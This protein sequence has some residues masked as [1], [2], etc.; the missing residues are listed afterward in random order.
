LRKWLYVPQDDSAFESI[1]DHLTKLVL[2]RDPR[3][4]VEPRPR[5]SRFK[6]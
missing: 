4:G 5:K 6:A 2:A 1:A 3:V